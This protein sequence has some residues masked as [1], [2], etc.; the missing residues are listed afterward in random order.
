MCYAKNCNASIGE[1]DGYVMKFT[2]VEIDLG[3]WREHVEA[4]ADVT[5]NGNGDGDDELFEEG[6]VIPTAG[7]SA[8]EPHLINA[9]A[10]FSLV[11]PSNGQP[12][13]VAYIKDQ[14]GRLLGFDSFTKRAAENTNEGGD[15]DDTT[16][17]ETSGLSLDGECTFHIV[18][19]ETT[20]IA[21][22]AIY[23]GAKKEDEEGGVRED[24]LYQTPEVPLPGV[25]NQKK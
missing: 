15:D 17:K 4:D 6:P 19:G 5:G 25:H 8:E 23:R 11:D 24:F 16:G 10:K 22:Y 13:E 20:S 7:G 2:G 14:K 21:A 9:Y 3:N 12:I 1:V 18:P